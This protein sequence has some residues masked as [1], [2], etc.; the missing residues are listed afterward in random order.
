LTDSPIILVIDD[1]SESLALLSGTLLAEGYQVR[2]ANSGRLAL[3]SLETA[4]PHL[5]LS[6]IRMPEIDGFEV[7]RQL[8]ASER[9]RHVPLI[10]LSAAKDVDE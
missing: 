3:A 4:L 2:A 7:C 10:F 5:I 1:E 6:D 9:T 8:K